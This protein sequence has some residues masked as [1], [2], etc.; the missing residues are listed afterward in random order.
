MLYLWIRLRNQSYVDFVLQNEEWEQFQSDLLMTVRV[1]NDLKTEAQVQSEMLIAENKGLKEKVKNLEAQI[2]RLKG[3]YARCYQCECLNK[4]TE[5][6]F[7][8]FLIEIGNVSM[9]RT[10]VT[11]NSRY[12]NYRNK[13]ITYILF[14][15]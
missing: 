11:I 3:E 1:A 13:F 6:A 15:S 4:I 14:L 7:G 10:E 2:D 12:L 9:P 5:I 8:Y